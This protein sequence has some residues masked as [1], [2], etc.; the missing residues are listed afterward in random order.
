MSVAN[1]THEEG[2]VG[3]GWRPGGRATERFSTADGEKNHV[4]QCGSPQPVSHVTDGA[5]HPSPLAGGSP[6]SP[7]DRGPVSSEAEA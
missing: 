4:L 2:A 7:A 5:A 3:T 1:R 6:Q